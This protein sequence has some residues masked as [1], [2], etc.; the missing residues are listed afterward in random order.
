MLH[1]YLNL[2]R[3]AW[4]IYLSAMSMLKGILQNL[5]TRTWRGKKLSSIVL[6]KSSLFLISLIQ[7][8]IDQ[9][10]FTRKTQQEMHEVK[11]VY[12]YVT[13]LLQ[14]CKLYG[15]PCIITDEYS[16]NQSELVGKLWRQNC[17]T[18]ETFAKLKEENHLNFPRW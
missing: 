15:D 11:K 5:E 3:Q 6:L 4:R 17:C 9:V 12:F 7:G 16:L 2:S 13:K 1:N 8:G 14:T 18:A 10:K